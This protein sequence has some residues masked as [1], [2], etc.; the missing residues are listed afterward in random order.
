MVV[1]AVTLYGGRLVTVWVV[2]GCV[3]SRMSVEM[4]C[5]S[6][7]PM[8]KE[9]SSFPVVCLAFQE[10]PLPIHPHRGSNLHHNTRNPH[11]WLRT[12]IRKAAM[13]SSQEV[14]SSS[15]SI[16]Q[17]TEKA[18]TISSPPRS[19][20]HHQCKFCA[21]AFASRNAMFRHVRSDPKCSRLA[22]NGKGGD[23]SQVIRMTRQTIA[24]KFAYHS[25]ISSND[26]DDCNQEK[27][28]STLH[29]SEAKLAG[30]MLLNA[31]EDA[32]NRYVRNELKLNSTV[33]EITGTTQTSVSNNRHKSLSQEV[34][35]AA[36]GD[37]VAVSF[38]GPAT[39]HTIPFTTQ[40]SP[41][42][43][44]SFLTSLLLATNE[45]LKETADEEMKETMPMST[46]SVQV[47]LLACKWMPLT[48]RFHAE[49]SC[50]QRIY[51]YLLPLCWL[52][53][54]KELERWWIDDQ[55]DEKD[56]V[57]IGEHSNKA[58]SRPPSDSLKLMKR[59][60]RSAESI[61]L[62]P[63]V[64]SDLTNTSSAQI[65]D[66]AARIKV[67]A[68]RFGAL[69]KKE[70]RAWHNF[71]DPNLRGDASPSNEPVWRALDFA[72]IVQLI[73]IPQ[74][75]GKIGEQQVIAVLE[76]RGDDFIQEQVRRVVGTALAVAH[77]WLPTNVFQ[78]ANR[79]DVFMETPLA[80]PGRLY[81]DNARF[82]FEELFTGKAFFEDSDA[83]VK[84]DNNDDS[85]INWLQRRLLVQ[86]SMET[87]KREEEIWI[88]ELRHKIAPRI[89]NQ[90][91]EATTRSPSDQPSLPKVS[92]ETLSSAPDGYMRT[93]K[94]LRD[95]VA[96]GTWLKTS[97]ARSRVISNTDV[98]TGL[99]N[100][101]MRRSGS[102]TVVNPKFRD[103]M[104][105][106]GIGSNALPLGN[107][108][109]PSL[110]DAVFGLEELLSK[111]EVE[112]T[113][114]NGIVATTKPS[115]ELR[116]PSSHCAINCNAQFTPHVDSGRGAGQS[117]SMIVGLGDYDGGKLAVEGA[118]HNIRYKPLQFDG[119]KLRHFTKSYQGERF[120]LVWFTPEL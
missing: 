98:S 107:T 112:M 88:E 59:A 19:P 120:S 69:A 41:E 80:P 5:L 101:A 118:F 87:T 55:I 83:K 36:M 86:R 34:G 33:I 31:V 22:N 85:S 60:L 21:Q 110:V 77:G 1:G 43:R 8:N 66:G 67:A 78:V 75:Q 45:I 62:P 35:S 27:R 96:S 51:H 25:T 14:T 81:L 76:F 15:S 6:S 103:G 18:S 40:E 64:L 73:T 61:N 42:S 2:V 38:L 20:Q 72:R 115:G 63:E 24:L 11:F 90:I 16:L 32:L 37:V 89:S 93:L 17:S 116:Q 108:M 9:K 23:D 99:D 106:D 46:T 12:G 102:F 97:Q 50:T 65:S 70:R 114:E 30:S 29:L 71:A 74:E 52:P 48:T 92:K 94:L 56:T 104:Y 49:R 13:D 4:G 26:S 117:L 3:F 82:H 53:D 111:V 28:N 91:F 84:D 39:T 7:Q 79:P 119:W 44:Q 95:I 54:G 47:L 10:S 68:G 57:A 58:K 109:F 113:N 105:K 100:V